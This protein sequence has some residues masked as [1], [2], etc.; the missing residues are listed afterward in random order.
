MNESMPVPGVQRLRRKNAGGP[1]GRRALCWTVGLF[2]LS[3]AALALWIPRDDFLVRDPV[4]H[5]RLR[6]LRLRIAEAPAPP[7]VVVLLGSSHVLFG[8]RSQQMARDVATGLSR[9]VVVANES[10]AGGGPVRSL[11]AMDRLRREGV[12]PDLVVFE[13]FPVLFDRRRD[14]TGSDV[15]PL[16][17]LDGGDVAL[18]RRYAANR[19]DLA[20]TPNLDAAPAYA[21]RSNLTNFLIPWLLPSSRRKKAMP[22]DAAYAPENSPAERRAR[23][24]ACEEA[25]YR[26]CFR[27]LSLGG[28]SQ[29]RAVSE[30]VAGLR[31]GGAKVVFLATPEGPLFR[32]WY[33]AGRWAQCTAWLRDLAASQGATSIDAREWTDNEAL[34]FDSHH[35]TPAGAE[36]FT[37]WLG[38]EVLVPQ[39]RE[40]G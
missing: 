38:R 18:L 6:L 8:L 11:L 20:E 30:L 12:V 4:R 27:D 10:V 24:L 33:P 26:S 23:A 32:S 35:L 17:S 22:E 34:F 29:D 19:P 3:Q 37:R 39:L 9:P 36:E 7:K 21:Q 40:G 31:A 28:A 5:D 2:V 1:W 13:T 25:H 15:L 14:E 16:E